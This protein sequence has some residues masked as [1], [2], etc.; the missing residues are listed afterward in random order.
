M[1]I[2]NRMAELHNEVTQ[3]R[4][5]IHSNPEL[6]YDVHETAANVA[7]R[8]KEFGCDEIVTGIGRTGVVGII[9]GKTKSSGR[10]VGLR[11]DM[12]ALPI[13]EATEKPYKSKIPG[14]MHACGHDGHTAMLL[15]AGKYL[16]ETRNF[17]GSVALIFQPAEEGGAGGKAM[18]EDGMMDR[19]G[20][21]EVYGMHNLPGVPV[22][23]FAICPGPIMAATDEFR[24]VI[25]GKG[26]HAALP[27]QGIDPVVTASQIVLGLQTIASRNINPFEPIVVSATKISAGTT[28]N[29][30]PEVAEILGTIRSISAEAREFAAKRLKEICEGIAQSAGAEV[31]VE[32]FEGYPVTFNH[33]D[34]T[35][36][37]V[38]V[39][40]MIAGKDR[41]DPN[42][43]ATMGG[44]DF[45]YMLLERPGAFIFMGNGE[46][47]GL[48]HPEYD[49]NDEAIPYGTSYWAKLTETLMPA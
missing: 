22:G 10:V 45:S 15:G 40:A 41:V 36:K 33:E 46:T 39:A 2:I 43:E 32:V 7:K 12:D 49:F 47:A 9:H 13:E 38:D 37:A 16:A 26:A 31:S 8:L 27:Q 35:Q 3:W 21:Q 30:I 34:E 20:I 1:P 18:V 28:Y 5:D 11:A 17:D 44:E 42:R 25:T 19:F 4:R 29:V 24:I 14:K 48:H 6:M 23:E